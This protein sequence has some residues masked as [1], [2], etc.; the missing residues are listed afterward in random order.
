MCSPTARSALAESMGQAMPALH[1]GA[2]G[3]SGHTMPTY[4]AADAGMS[5]AVVHSHQLM[6]TLGGPRAGRRQETHRVAS[7]N[8]AAAEP[9]G[10]RRL[11][12]ASRQRLS[13]FAAVQCGV[14]AHATETQTAGGLCIESARQDHAAAL[15]ARAVASGRRASPPRGRRTLETDLRLWEQRCRPLQPETTPHRSWLVSGTCLSTPKESAQ[16]GFSEGQGSARSLRARTAS[17]HL[18]APPPAAEAAFAGDTWDCAYLE[19]FDAQCPGTSTARRQPARSCSPP[20][21]PN[22]AVATGPS[23]LDMRVARETEHATQH[24]AW[25][26]AKSPELRKPRQLKPRTA[27]GRLQNIVPWH[28]PAAGDQHENVAAAVL[29][30]RSLEALQRGIAMHSGTSEQRTAGDCCSP[31]HAKRGRLRSGKLRSPD[32]EARR[33]QGHEVLAAAVARARSPASKFVAQTCVRGPSRSELRHV[34]APAISW[35]P[36]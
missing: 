7:A 5:A 25:L 28:V 30:R 33:A 24:R 32:P 14:Q 35:C 6:M 3:S 36:K 22:V 18:K 9:A 34:P 10:N 4:P 1:T 8:S 19:P 17:T 11:A 29:P 12:S 20:Q 16:T 21:R 26:A 2:A 15:G 31:S 27:A 13:A 23:M